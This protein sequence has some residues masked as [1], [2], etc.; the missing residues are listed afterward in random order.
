MIA[1]T[2]EPTILDTHGRK[3][4]PRT[5]VLPQVCTRW[6]PKKLSGPRVADGI[7]SY[8]VPEWDIEFGHYVNW[9]LHRL[10]A[11]TLTE[12][13][14]NGLHSVFYRYPQDYPIT[15]TD[16]H[17]PLSGNNTIT[18]PNPDYRPKWTTTF[19]A[20]VRDYDRD[21]DLRPPTREMLA[22][23]AEFTGS[24]VGVAS[25]GH[26]LESPLSPQPLETV[27]HPDHYNANPSGVEAID[28][29]EHLTFNVGN[30]IKYLWRA[31]HKGKQIEDL[32]KARWY[33]DREIQ[34]L[35]KLT[36]DNKGKKA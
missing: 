5:T 22:R 31:D 26:N 15:M 32:K 20:S 35:E 12:G 8:R 14:W 29:I 10:R 19:S 4:T 33:V 25:P 34:R 23:I 11:F 36:D 17:L 9:T 27:N 28:V 30:A 18:V 24:C 2:F 16:A 7:H 3:S 21:W 6:T 1:V 13:D